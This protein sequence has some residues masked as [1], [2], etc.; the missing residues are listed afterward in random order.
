MTQWDL[1]PNLQT[2]TDA[3]ERYSVYSDWRSSAHTEA[4]QAKRQ[5]EGVRASPQDLSKTILE[6]KGTRFSK[7]RMLSRQKSVVY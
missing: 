6:C 7:K 5:K 2:I 1:E 3:E 4:P